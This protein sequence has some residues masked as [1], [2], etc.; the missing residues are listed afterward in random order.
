MA[1]KKVPLSNPHKSANQ[2]D[3]ESW[4]SKFKVNWQNKKK[5]TR[6]IIILIAVAVLSIAGILISYLVTAPALDPAAL[7]AVEASYIIDREDREVAQLHAEE[8]RIVVPIDEIP[9]QLQQAFIAIEDERFEKHRGIDLLSFGRAIVVNIRDR[10][11]SQGGSTITQQLIRNTLLGPEKTIKR[12][13]QEMWLALRLERIKSKEEVL[14]MYL[15]RICFGNGIYGVE[16]A[17]RAYF[18]KSTGELDLPE[19]ALLAGIVR[20]PEYY[21]PFN[22]EEAAI[23]RMKLVLGNMKRLGF[24]SPTEYEEAVAAELDFAEPSIPTFPYPYFVDYVVHYELI[25]ILEDIPEFGSREKAYEAIYNGG[26]RIYTTMYT[27]YQ[28][29]LENVLN[30]ADLYPQTIYINMPK[31][32]QAVQ[33]NNGRLPADYPSAY[34][35]EENGVPQPQSAMVLAD[36]KNGEI[37]ALGGGRDYCKNRNELLRYL[38][39]RQPGSAIKPIIDYGPSF[40]E[41][42]LGVGSVLDDSPL[43]GPQGW[44]PENY[45]GAFR[46]IVTVRQA[47]AHSYN[48]PAIRTYTEHI[49]LQK[50]AEKAFEMGISTY[51]PRK[52]QPVPSWAIG[53]REV[54]ALDMAQAYSVLANNGVKMETHTVRRIEDRHGKII[55]EHK[56]KPEQVLSSGAAFMT[57]SILRDVVT[58]TTARGLSGLGRPLAAKTGTTDDS[59]DIYLAAYA[60]NVVATFWMG[61]D[62]KDMGKIAS[63]WNYSSGM[64]RELF[65]ELFK[66]LPQENFAPQPSEVVRVEVCTKSGLLPSEQCRE[67]GTVRADYF[68]RNHVPRLSCDKHVQL[69]ICEASGLLAGEFCPAEQVVQKSFFK[70]P[71]YLVTDGNWK[72]GAGRAPLDAKEAPPGKTCDIH[73]EHFGEITYFTAT[74]AGPGQVNLAW[75]YS[76]EGLKGFQLYRQIKNG[77]SAEPQLIKSPGKN[78]KSYQDRDVQTGKTYLYTIYAVSEQGTRSQPKVAEVTVGDIP[79]QRPGKPKILGADVV[80]NSV[81]LSWSPA[82]MLATEFIVKREGPGGSKSETVPFWKYRYEDKDPEPGEYIYT[83]TASNSH[84]KSEPSDPYTVT[85]TGNNSRAGDRA[86][87]SWSL[88]GRLRDLLVACISRF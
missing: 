75:D 43:I 55:Y 46:G 67:A 54:T 13:V 28:D 78:E 74:V 70:R 49:G 53:S 48:I 18:G 79:A 58:S 14:E 37:W 8:N 66:T 85:I 47:L 2:K 69:D 16:A 68:L 15:N 71:K 30:R 36:P 84:G 39:L 3:N 41:G 32:E 34:I 25:N 27:D 11:F 31:L 51:D 73:T 38:S 61:Y 62:I 63:G 33:D 76:G 81:I 12:K 26:L 40:N 23:N 45:D 88:A 9:E 24:I 5:S 6:V 20:T 87:Y 44:R 83:V 64:I 10:S 59:R 82:D 29:H 19:S 42:L 7:E 57:T 4:I 52:A 80:N 50:G 77:D 22:D 56:P 72:K 21:N 35:D 65:R 60:P 17:S 86:R 1:E